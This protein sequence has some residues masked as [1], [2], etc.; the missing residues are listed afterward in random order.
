[1]CMCAYALM[2]V[3]G[4]ANYVATYMH[5]TKACVEQ[6]FIP[7]NPILTEFVMMLVSPFHR[8]PL[9]FCH[10]STQSE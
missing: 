4:V 10:Q 9:T 5:S 6:I 2:F 1:M 8:H 3:R 7:L